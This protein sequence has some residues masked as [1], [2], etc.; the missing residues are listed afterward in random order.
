MLEAE[1]RRREN[2]VQMQGRIKQ[3]LSNTSLKS[4]F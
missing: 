1:K 2:E 4:V 3:L